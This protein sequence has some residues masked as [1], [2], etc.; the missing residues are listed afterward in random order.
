M[1]SESGDQSWSLSRRVYAISV[2]LI[3]IWFAIAWAAT[4][5]YSNRVGDQSIRD[6]VSQ[7]QQ[8]LD[9]VTDQIDNALRILRNV[10][11]IVAGNVAVQRELEQFG[12]SVLTSALSYQERKRLWT[13]RSELTGTQDFLRRAA[14]GLDADVVWILNA[15][16]DCVASSNADSSGSFVGTNYSEREY[17][18]QAQQGQL[19]QQY[20]VGKVS[21]VPG[22]FYS[23]PVLDRENNFIGAVIV[24]RDISN[25]IIWTRP[26]NAFIADSSGV[27]VLTE[28]NRL[29]YRTMPDS[30]AEKLSPEIRIARYR[31]SDLTHIDLEPWDRY[32]HSGLVSIGKSTTPFVLKSKQIADGK[33][34]VY[35]ARPVAGLNRLEE[36]K[37]WLFLL[38]S[39]AGT[40]LIVAIAVLI[41][42]FRGA[43]HGRL[44][45]E[46][47]NK[48]KSQFLA[49]MSHEIRTPMNGVIGMANLLL[50]TQLDSQQSEFVLNIVTSG[51][52]LLSIINDILDLSKIEAGRMEFE[53]HAFNVLT[54]LQSVESM[55]KIRAIEKG[56][57]FCLDIHSEAENTFVG[58]SLRISQVLLN[59]TGN[60]VKFTDSGEVRVR[61][62]RQARGLRFEVVDSGIG[63]PLEARKK[64]FSNFSQV[65]ASTTR[66]FGGTGLGLVICKHLV[67][68]MG[69]SI[70]VQDGTGRGSMF[71]V[72]I[73]LE[74]APEAIPG[75]LP[76]AIL[77]HDPVQK[78]KSDAALASATATAESL[79]SQQNSSN[80]VSLP[81]LLVEDH[82]INQQLVLT[83]LRRWGYSAM[84]A[85]NGSEGVSAAGK[86]PFAIIL[87][88]MQMPIMDG[89]EA[90]RIIR[91]G[92]GPN[93]CTPIIALT[94]N[95][96]QSDRKVCMAAG[97]SDFLSKPIKKDLLASCLDRWIYHAHS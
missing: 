27:V 3:A 91:N 30:T 15:S 42:Y 33:I 31:T 6:N 11:L 92:D 86:E 81:I 94:A 73:P 68:G 43:S 97:M 17:F 56:I 12:Y 57:G 48:A 64:L 74:P 58:D 23:Y 61:V 16:G 78:S 14:S 82:K 41:M 75:D 71:W 40:M 5:Y 72:D 51:E 63:I 67:E 76:E 4:N 90:T 52:S 88:D 21:K 28:D 44:V 18:I 8:Q 54:L 45:A 10:P 53:K 29:Q 24:K 1:D 59:L 22:F 39:F 26:V 19:G 95:A 47:A 25:F 84:L 60:A 77:P 49:N 87:M 83:L 38:S 13:A 62:I 50:E 7:A 79:Q 80:K 37:V 32:S 66:K 96:M 9:G 93:R 36:E 34:T 46:I 65:D 2:V 70:G 20:A 55:V 69:G 85:E 89:L 35:V